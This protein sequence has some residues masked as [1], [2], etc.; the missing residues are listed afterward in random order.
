M[1]NQTSPG[2]AFAEIDNTTRAP[3]QD[4]TIGAYVGNFRWGPVLEKTVVVSEPD[5]VAKFA[6]PSVD[7]S[8]DFHVAAQFLSYTRNLQVVRNVSSA[9]RNAN[10]GGDDALVIKNQDDYDGQSLA[11]ADVGLWAAKYPGALGNSLRVSLQGVVT[12]AETTRTAFNAWTYGSFFDGPPGTSDYADRYGSS[13]D[14]IHVVVVDE[15]GLFTGTPG[16]VLETFPFL[17]QASDAKLADGSSNY[18]KDVINA[19]SRY[20]W[21]GDHDDASN[22]PEA[23]TAAT[24]GTDYL[25][26]ATNGRITVSLSG[27]VDSAAL[28]SSEIL[29]GFAEFEDDVS[30]FIGPDLPSGSATTIANGLIA[31]AD[32]AKTF[33]VTLS[34]PSTALTASA[35]KTFADTITSSSYGILDSGRLVVY[36]KYNDRNINIPASGSVAGI[37][38]ETD[39]TIGPWNSPGGLR[40]GQIRNVTKLAYNP[41]SLA[42][43]DT[44]YKARVNPIVTFPGEGTLLFGDKTALARPSAFDRINVRRLFIL[45][46]KTVSAA[47]RDVLFQNNTEFTRSNFVSLVEPVLRGIQGRG[48]IT[49]F[50]VVCDETNNPG[51]VIDR[52]EFVADIYIQPARS[53][54]F[55]QLNFIATRTGVSFSTLV[56]GAN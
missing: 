46:E 39:R 54:N 48:G 49:E 20:I 12:D 23:G 41:S 30:F 27:G 10:A 43:R 56:G 4:T 40:R 8:V 19:R 52:Q 51:D 15:D 2:V 26:S 22:M 53:I 28:G 18:Y 38:A 11:F 34:P 50:A 1:L 35:I 55:I 33:V 32:A 5:L 21:F 25:T 14:E 37:M 9:A 16:K 44:L 47:A 13:N 31:L 36:D 24:L 7:N 6:A 42:D 29:A 3:A 17:S 45:L